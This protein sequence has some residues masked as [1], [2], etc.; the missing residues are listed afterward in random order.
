MYLTEIWKIEDTYSG[1][2]MVAVPSIRGCPIQCLVHSSSRTSS[3]LEQAIYFTSSQLIVERT[4]KLREHRKTSGRKS[5][6]ASSSCRCFNKRFTFSTGRRILVSCKNRAK[7]DWRPRLYLHRLND[8][9]SGVFKENIS[10]VSTFYR[11]GYFHP[12]NA[13]PT[14]E[15]D[16][17]RRIK[18]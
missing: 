4:W 15:R 17:T 10:S 14:S 12:L 5:F 3:L 9:F 13:P 18:V 8:S 6:R 11:R 16:Y 7:R 2:I 1:V